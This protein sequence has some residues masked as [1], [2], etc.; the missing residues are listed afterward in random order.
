MYSRQTSDVGGLDYNKD[1]R[2]Q[3][4]CNNN[5]HHNGRNIDP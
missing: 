1:D 2:K 3:D 5:G 4:N